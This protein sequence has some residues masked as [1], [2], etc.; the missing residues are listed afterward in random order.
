M[1]DSSLPSC[2]HK[3]PFP[4]MASPILVGNVTWWTGGVRIWREQSS[5]L[6]APERLEVRILDADGLKRW[7]FIASSSPPW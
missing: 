3:D 2:S 6:H 7:C 1:V 4:I 5:Y